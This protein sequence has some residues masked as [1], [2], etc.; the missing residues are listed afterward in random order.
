MFPLVRR[1]PIWPQH[2]Q[3]SAIFHRQRGETRAA[4][5]MITLSLQAVSPLAGEKFLNA[6]YPLHRGIPS[7][8]ARVLAFGAAAHADLAAAQTHKPSRLLTLAPADILVICIYFALVLGI[9]VYL[10]RRVQASKDFFFAVNRWED[11]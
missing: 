1:E 11:R 9:G 8:A 6:S 5:K 10:K 4:S 7:K 2:E 3:A